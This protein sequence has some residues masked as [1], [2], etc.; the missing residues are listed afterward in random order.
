MCVC[1]YVLRLFSRTGK[2]LTKLNSKQSHNYKIAKGFFFFFKGDIW[3][4]QWWPTPLIP[5]H[6]RQRQLD[7]YEFE[8][9]LVYSSS[10]RISKAT[11]RNPILKTKTLKQHE[12]IWMTA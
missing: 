7:F 5:A 4:G 10:S 9:S 8:A 6:G 3:A 12:D 1:I 2:E 11:Q